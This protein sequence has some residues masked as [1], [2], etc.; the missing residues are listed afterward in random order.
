MRILLLWLLS[1]CGSALALD[2]IAELGNPVMD[3]K[4][5][6]ADN[7]IEFVGIQLPDELVTPGLSDSERQE[8]EKAYPIRPLNRR[9]KTF[10]NIEQDKTLL[11]R[12]RSYALR[13]NLTVL[14]EMRLHKRRQLNKYRY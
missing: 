13:Y 5:A 9:W 1:C 2:D 12:Y 6:V 10:Q 14:K 8:L 11:R 4:Q 7:N 3:A